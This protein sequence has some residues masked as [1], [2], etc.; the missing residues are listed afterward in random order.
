[1]NSLH[2]VVHE[3]MSSV[4]IQL[5]QD[6]M[7]RP[8]PSPKCFSCVSVDSFVVPKRAEVRVAQR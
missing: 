6:V 7:V 8:L 2:R 3:Y 4:L 1:M 5:Y